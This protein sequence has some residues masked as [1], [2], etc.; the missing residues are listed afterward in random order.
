MIADVHGDHGVRRQML[1]QGVEHR[2]GT[3]TPPAVIRGAAGFLRSPDRAAF[4]HVQPLVGG[5]HLAQGVGQCGHGDRRVAQHVCADGVEA[6]DRGVV[7][8]DLH[9]RFVRRD[10]GVVRK[11]RPDDDQQIRFVHQPAHRPLALKVV[12]TGAVNRSVSRR[13][14][15]AALCQPF[16]DT[17]RLPS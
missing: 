9:D 8:V 4:G 11:R 1:R 5:F 10:T 13:T 17:P 6:P 12:S 15:P 2:G 3:D 14:S 16:C 7:V